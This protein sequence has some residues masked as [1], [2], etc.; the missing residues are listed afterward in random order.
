[1]LIN[2]DLVRV[3]EAW[4]ID[5]I[6]KAQSVSVPATIDALS[7]N[8]GAQ[9]TRSALE[10]TQSGKFQ[11]A[12]GAWW[13]LTGNIR[14]ANNYGSLANAFAA[15]YAIT[16]T[17]GNYAINAPT[18][19]G[20]GNGLYISGGK[21]TCLF[22]FTGATASF[23]FNYAASFDDHVH[24]IV[25]GLHLRGDDTQTLFRNFD[26]TYFSLRDMV[27][28]NA[29]IGLHHSTS[30]VCDGYKNHYTGNRIGLYLENVTAFL[31]TS[32]YIRDNTEAGI[33]ITGVSSENFT[34]LSGAIEGNRCVAVKAE[35]IS[36]EFRLRFD[37]VY[38]E[39][40]GDKAANINSVEIEKTTNG[41]SVVTMSGGKLSY[42]VNVPL[43]WTSG[44]Y[45]WGNNLI[46]DGVRV[47]GIHY[48]DNIS[49]IN[50]TLLTGCVF[51]P[52]E[53]P[54]FVSQW[55]HVLFNNG[56]NA[57]GGYSFGCGLGP[58]L[59]YSDEL[60]SDV[61]PTAQ[62]FAA[63]QLASNPP[64]VIASTLDYGEGVFSE[65]TFNG[66]AGGF[67]NNCALLGTGWTNSTVRVMVLMVQADKDCTLE[68][69]MTGSAA[70]AGGV[71]KCLANK[72]QRLFI[73]SKT[74]QVTEQIYLYPVSTNSPVVN[75]FVQH[76]CDFDTDYEASAFIK[77]IVG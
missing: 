37:D 68:Y 74:A 29:D 20:S 53:V 51:N 40:D 62:P 3:G 38:F 52:G 42:N 55:G 72:M 27:F 70:V 56:Q 2:P 73:I 5:T 58:R 23:T 65:I 75:V 69:L 18:P 66:M 7:L 34:F 16:V 63:A 31:E 71:F 9:Y 4:F 61:A 33:Y 50:G 6:A 19:L 26:G 22:N 48:V 41:H 54:V 47:D 17:P 76:E 64:T 15:D 60:Y 43:A 28:N 46:L 57:A 30:Y 77:R 44:D 1:M 36:D 14:N 67:G 24:K 59:L 8:N 13:E 35:T 25:S 32:V 10:P 39:L 11:S 49:I 12:D 45:L 21:D